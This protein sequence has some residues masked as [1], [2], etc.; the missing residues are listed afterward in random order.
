MTDME[1]IWDEEYIEAKEDRYTSPGLEESNWQILSQPLIYS[2]SFTSLGDSLLLPVNRDE[3]IKKEEYDVEISKMMKNPDVYDK[4][5]LMMMSIY[6]ELVDDICVETC[7]EMH[8]KL[9]RGQLCLNCDSVYA[10]TISKPNCDIFGQNVE[11][12]KKGDS[13]ECDNCK[14]IVTASR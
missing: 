11:E 13:F 7:F 5:T 9:K 8:K 14:R 6:L 4:M 3:E 10:D 2:N 12:L 1:S